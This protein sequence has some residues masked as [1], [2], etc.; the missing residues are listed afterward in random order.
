MA[1]IFNFFF[2][3]SFLRLRSFFLLMGFFISLRNFFFRFRLSF[4]AIGGWRWLVVA[5]AF[6]AVIF[7]LLNGFCVFF[8]VFL[9]LR[10]YYGICYFGIRIIF[11]H[12]ILPLLRQ[13]EGGLDDAEFQLILLFFKLKSLCLD[14][15]P[16]IFRR[17]V[18]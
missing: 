17:V 6:F 9:W 18:L 16:V 7:G 11:R 1:S 15:F 10:W 13:S 2:R 14:I 12:A 4:S 8:D 5:T 3:L